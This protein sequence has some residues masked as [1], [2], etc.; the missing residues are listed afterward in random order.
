VVTWHDRTT[1]Q[2][3]FLA[4]SAAVILLVA[5]LCATP[6]VRPG[7]LGRAARRVRA[8]RQAG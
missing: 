2:R 3:V 8:R 7:A 4:I 5:A 6:A 1:V